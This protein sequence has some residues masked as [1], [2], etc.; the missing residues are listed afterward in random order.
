MEQDEMSEQLGN[1]PEE[2]SDAPA[3]V[4]PPPRRGKEPVQ[5]AQTGGRPVR[6]AR[7]S[8]YQG[9]ARRVAPFAARSARATLYPA[10]AEG[11]PCPT[12]ET[13]NGHN[14]DG[15]EMANYIYALGRVEPRFP[16]MAVEREFA[17][18]TGRA[19]TAG[20]TDRQA[21]SNV[22]SQRE[23]RYLVRQLCYVLTIQGVDTYIL[24]PSDP[25]D[26][27]MLVNASR[28]TPTPADVDIV[29]GTRGPIAPPEMCNGLQVPIVV[30]EQIYSFDRNTILQAIPR[31]D[32]VQD[33]TAFRAAAAEVFDRI[34]QLVDNAGATDEHRALNYLA[35]RYPAIYAV[36]A[37][38]H[39]RN[40]FLTGV[41]VRPS[42]LSGIRNIVDVIFSDT[43]RQT[44]V[45]EQHFVRVDVTEMFPFL[46]TRMQSFFER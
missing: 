7:M 11:A 40:F 45:T 22:L 21:L 32:T 10:Q 6:R 16:S 2:A 31:P 23:N 18:A 25:A 15:G 8:P 26:F 1:Q 42:R 36:A 9:Q 44:D 4:P 14:P 35:A 37:E 20:L 30:F 46:V 41:E 3:I 28:A 29:I 38:A 13:M 17:Q 34:V 24:Q 33:E 43:N 5:P 27:D 19:D 12:C 39:Q